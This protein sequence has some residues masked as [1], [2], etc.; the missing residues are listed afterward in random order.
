MAAARARASSLYVGRTTHIR[1]RPAANRFEY[2]LFMACVD[3]AELEAGTLDAW[4]LFSSRT[5]WALTALLARD[6]LGGGGGDDAPLSERVRAVV[7]E[8]TGVAPAGA[9][10]LLAGLRVLGLE[11]NPVSFYYVLGA[12]G[13]VDVLVAEVSNIPWFERHLYVLQPT[14]AAGGR[15]WG[16]GG[17]GGGSGG[18]GGG[19]GDG[20][21]GGDGD[22]DG[23]GGGR[24][25]R[26]A[27]HDKA[28]HVSPFMPITG[29]KYDW[30]VSRPADRLAVRIGLSDPRGP[31]FSASID[32]RRRPFR[33]AHLLWLLA[34]YPLMTVKVVLAIMYEAGR[35][36]RRG[37]T[38]YPHPRGAETAASAAIAAVVAFG[39]RTRGR[40][41]AAAAAPPVKEEAAR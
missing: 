10:R 23:D 12:G 34:S 27:A 21:R 9:V 37:F 38:F 39:V 14:G 7:Q 31:F 13:E 25:L 35:L 30:L 29:I 18:D 16:G 17:D 3:L 6:H 40:F 1:R 28:F 11:F 26:F 41:G 24:L 8:A 19:S 5:P 4:P 2:A 20:G 36:W 32:M 15:A 33:P 22:G